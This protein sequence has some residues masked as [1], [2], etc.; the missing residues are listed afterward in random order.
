MN[1][2]ISFIDNKEH[3]T[4]KNYKNDG[5]N[6]IALYPAMMVDEMQEELLSEI[7]KHIDDCKNV[8]DPFHGAGTSLIIAQKLGLNPIGIDINPLAN[9]ITYVKLYNY[10][11]E[12]LKNKTN[13]LI[14]NVK[15]CINFEILEFNNIDK[16]FRKDVKE[17]LSK[18][19]HCIKM[20]SD[21]NIRKFFWV[22]FANIVR[23]FSNSRS[24][25]FKLH[26]KE[27]EKIENM[28]NN[29]ID[30]FFNDC[31]LNIEKISVDYSKSD[32]TLYCGDSKEELNKIEDNSI[33]IICTSPPY[34][35]NGTTVTYGQFSTLQLQWIDLNDL[36]ENTKNININN[37]SIDA[38]SLGGKKNIN[39]TKISCINEYLKNI[40]KE[41][42]SKIINFVEDYKEVFELMVSKVKQGGYIIIT[43]GNRKVDNIKVPFDEVNIEL[44]NS[45]KMKLIQ[46][47]SRDIVNKRMAGKVSNVENVGSV[48]SMK[49]E[50]I[51]IFRKEA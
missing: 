8:L 17:D 43:L 46:K 1:T 39:E 32:F 40:T 15:R 14:E 47:L 3:W 18:I 31:Q 22:S 48:E 35:D 36:S 28:E 26:I 27:K 2:S 11:I 9:L 12:E 30:K 6:S 49:E 5:I 13:A 20:E 42:H 23:K 25:T 45:N 4:Y 38:N 50:Y 44:A 34:G 19:R 41:K 51:L 37:S 24:S 16:W 29:L 10:N 33:S 7:L 21:M